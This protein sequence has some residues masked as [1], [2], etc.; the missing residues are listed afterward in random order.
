[1]WRIFKMSEEKQLLLADKNLISFRNINEYQLRKFSS[2]PITPI[3]ISS[4]IQKIVLVLD[5]MY[6]VASFSR[7]FNYKDISTNKHLYKIIGNYFLEV[8]ENHDH[9]P[10]YEEFKEHSDMIIEKLFK[11]LIDSDDTF[12]NKI[13]GS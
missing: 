4:T 1:M 13:H 7:Q 6:K 12:R 10:P 5:A 3:R 8:F 11:K 9:F 2:L